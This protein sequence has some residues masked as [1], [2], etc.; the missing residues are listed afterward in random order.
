[1]A[2]FSDQPD[3][4]TG[5]ARDIVAGVRPDELRR[6]FAD[7]GRVALGVAVAGAV[8]RYRHAT[9]E[10]NAEAAGDR[11]SDADADRDPDL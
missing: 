4:L 2:P 1:M 3:E 5:A 10:R 11:P 8:R 9:A 7:V 6:S